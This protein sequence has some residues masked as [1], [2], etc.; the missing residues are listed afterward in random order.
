MLEVKEISCDLI[1][2]QVA[3]PGDMKTATMLSVKKQAS[4]L[5]SSPSALKASGC[6]NLELG[7]VAGFV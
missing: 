4:A 1:H 3:S 5:L 6:L 2:H 7:L